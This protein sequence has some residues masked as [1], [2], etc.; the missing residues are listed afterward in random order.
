MEF[1]IYKG[2]AIMGAFSL[3]TLLQLVAPYR[4]TMHDIWENWKINL[5]LAGL[6]LLL[7]GLVCRACVCT[8]ANAADVHGFGLTNMFGWS[9]ELRVGVAILV[10]D[11][12][13]YVWHRLNHRL[14]ILWRF[15]AVHHSDRVFDV[16]TAL[17]FHP[18]ELL[19]SLVVRLLIVG[20]IGLPVIGILAFEIMY[21]FFNFLE[22]GNIRLPAPVESLLAI[23]FLTPALHRKHHSV[24]VDELNRNFGTIFSFWDKIFGTLAPSASTES[25][26]VGLP[27]SGVDPFRLGS[28]LRLPFKAL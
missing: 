4:G 13:A 19:I 28:L 16:S 18:G 20:A 9:Q 8:L 14:P 7:I 17:R 26:V 1:Q 2:A 15:H 5:P 21:G 11:L 22:H 24:K 12:V 25:I 6:N 23:A 3:T 27:D 10:L